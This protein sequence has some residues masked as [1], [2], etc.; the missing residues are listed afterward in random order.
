M[1]IKYSFLLATVLLLSKSESS[2]FATDAKEANTKLQGQVLRT[3]VKADD[4]PDSDTDTPY[5]E[6][7]YHSNASAIGNVNRHPT[8]QKE[9]L[10]HHWTK[11]M[12][13]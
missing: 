2:V 7:L 5:Q 11:S 4:T 13:I 10:L 8:W 6:S 1:K 9:A 12:I 3:V